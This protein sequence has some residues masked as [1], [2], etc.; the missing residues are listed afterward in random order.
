MQQA[1][2]N[3]NYINGRWEQRGAD[4]VQ[5]LNK[6]SNEPIATVPLATAQQVDDAIAG[7]AKAFDEYRQWSAE[8]RSNLLAQLANKLRANRSHFEALIVAEAGKPRS[9]AQNEVSRCLTTLQTAAE[10]ALRIT[11]ETVPMDM[12]AGTGKT[13]F[14]QRFPVGPISAISPFN[15]PLNLAL[16]KIAPALACGCP[17]VLKPSPFAPL[18]AL[19]FAALCA[20]TE[21]PA[22]TLNVLLAANEQAQQL[23]TDHRIKV[24]SFTGSPAVGWKLKSLAGKK[25][26]VLELGGNAAVLVDESADIE[27]AANTVA[28][29]AF[30]YAGQICISTQRVYVVNSRFEAFKTALLNEISTIEVGDPARENVRVGPIISADHLQRI[31]DWVREAIDAGAVVLAGGNVASSANNLYQPTVLTNTA[32]GMKVV[33]EEVFGPVMVLEPVPDFEAGLAA[34]NNSRFGL[35]AGVFTNRIDQ[36]KRA[37]QTLELG[38]VIIN[39]VPGFRVDPMPYGGVK[40]SGLGREGLRYAIEDFTEPRLLVY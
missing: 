40:D 20:E 12:G 26:V 34:V 15:F 30:L 10:E 23:V 8:Q 25:K 32:P 38:A 4:T 24:L 33:D 28:N 14:T 16:H 7:A 17:V 39:N 36:M 5:V 27:R 35:Q 31:A 2:S 9:Y 29:G 11:G 21:L 19:A 1:I 3:A 18:T 37:H 13:A 22:G 6:F